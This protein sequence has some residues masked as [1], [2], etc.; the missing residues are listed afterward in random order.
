MT[1]P[2]RARGRPRA[3]VVERAPAADRLHGARHRA[4]R[5]APMWARMFPA[6]RRATAL[7]HALDRAAEAL[8]DGWP[9]LWSVPT[10]GLRWLSGRLRPYAGL[11]RAVERVL[12]R[13]GRRRRHCRPRSRTDDEWCAGS[14][15]PPDPRTRPSCSAHGGTRPRT[16]AD[17]LVTGATGRLGTPARRA[18]RGTWIA[19][20]RPL[21]AAARGRASC[22]TPL[23]DI[24]ARRSRRR[25]RRRRRRGGR[26]GGL[27][28]RRRDARTMG[29]ARAR[30]GRGH[31]TRGRRAS[32]GTGSRGWST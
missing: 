11:R 31:A 18:S 17:A 21:P 14:R 22:A 24:V 9:A 4:A 27:P 15:R 20:A 30:H 1:G 16:G 3:A 12:R 25:D 26:A 29:R 8:D 19:R 7:P 28:R 23:V 5:C 13:A 2:L 6:I 32:S 10:N